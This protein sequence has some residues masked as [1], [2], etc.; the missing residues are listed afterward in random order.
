MAEFSSV[1]ANTDTPAR[2][3]E[4]LAG[5]NWSVVSYSFEQ[6]FVGV[7]SLLRLLGLLCVELLTVGQIAGVFR[8]DVGAA[9]VFQEVG[10]GM[11][12]QGSLEH[13]GGAW[14][15]ERLVFLT[16]VGHNIEL[17]IGA[18][19][20]LELHHTLGQESRGVHDPRQLSSQVVLLLAEEEGVSVDVSF[21]VT[22]EKY[23]NLTRGNQ[24]L[25][26]KVWQSFPLGEGVLGDIVSQFIDTS[27]AGLKL[28]V[29]LTLVAVTSFRGFVVFSDLSRS[30]NDVVVCLRAVNLT[31]EAERL[32]GL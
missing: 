18:F 21:K 14:N 23:L 7:R 10:L 32:V 31:E 11:D 15:H 27:A 29:S 9:S 20:L 30:L 17:S 3:L 4:F 28:G 2:L 24:V 12:P 16:L 1:T 5:L 13:F 22:R 8:R 6:L 19:V 25:V 26:R